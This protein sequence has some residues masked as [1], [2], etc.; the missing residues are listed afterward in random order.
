MQEKPIQPKKRGRPRKTPL[1]D[2]N[3][4]P[5]EKRGRGRPRKTEASPQN[6]PKEKPK[7][8]PSGVPPSERKEDTPEG[9]D[10]VELKDKN[11]SRSSVLRE[12]EQGMLPEIERIDFESLKN[13][14]ST[15]KE[16]FSKEVKL[17]VAA[18]KQNQLKNVAVQIPSS[19]LV[20]SR[21][22]KESLLKSCS[23][24]T[25]QPYDLSKTLMN[26]TNCLLL[27]NCLGP[28]F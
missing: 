5:K 13:V 6:I 22:L 27:G 17:I 26:E 24:F 8:E 20:W 16:K 12:K 19:Q 11:V 23:L 1:P 10:F 2:I 21:E 9:S 28:L 14:L 18:E 15:K 7:S 3:V 25:T 4:P